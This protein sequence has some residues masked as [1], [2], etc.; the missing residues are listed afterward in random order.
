MISDKLKPTGTLHIATDWAE[1]AKEILIAI[2]YAPGLVNATGAGQFAIKPNWRP[3]T[4]YE[5]RGLK[6]GHR[7][8]GWVRP[9]VQPHPNL[10][11]FVILL[12]WIHRSVH[13]MHRI[14]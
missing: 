10:V 7:P 8:C 5:R 4:K 3:T 14:A 12:L 9:L 1:Y 11:L 13:R 6:L 2:E